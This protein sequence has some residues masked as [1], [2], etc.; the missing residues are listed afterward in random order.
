MAIYHHSVFQSINLLFATSTALVIDRVFDAPVDRLWQAL[1][2]TESIKEWYFAQV[3]QFE[4]IVGFVFGFRDD[5]S[6]YQKEWKITQ[7]VEGQKLAHT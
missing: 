2:E 6:S 5:S 1:T 3:Q 7:V 4:P